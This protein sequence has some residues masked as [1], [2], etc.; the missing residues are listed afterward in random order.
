MTE[1]QLT[2]PVTKKY[3]QDWHAYNLAK[4]NEKRLFYELLYDLS[5]I[6]REPE[7]SF[8]RP[9][10]PIRDLFFC[11]GL[12][13]YSGYSGRKVI[14]DVKHAHGAGLISRAPHFN[15]LTD[16][17]N[18]P[19]TYDLLSKLVTI[20]A[21]PLRKLEDQYSIDSSGFGAYQYE[22]WM[23]VK[24]GSKKGYRNYLKGHVMIGTRTNIICSCEITPGNFSD[25][26]QMPSLLFKTKDNFTVKEVSADKAYTSKMMFRIMGSLGM[27]P[28]IPFKH[29]A[30]LAK[31][32][33]APLWNEM[34]LFFK[35]NQKK[36]A[37][38]Y[39]RRS[40]VET[41]FSMIKVR[42]GEFLK[43]KTYTAQRNELLMKFIC[44]NICCL[45]QEMYENDVKVDFRECSIKF[46]DRKVPVEFVT[47][48]A[49]KV[50]D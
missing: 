12:K 13:L 4:T 41:V 43:C 45:I 5:R 22:R 40:N 44:H 30:K 34:F 23:R 50:E 9:P 27:L 3:T 20:S 28:V 8:G 26:K 21:M 35:N 42:L 48:D 36:F 38:K 2:L 46:I 24:W 29:N 11:L 17:M 39:H 31:E 33:D 25:V 6:I 10:V 1:Q 15:T 49:S 14:S 47:R 37:E 16:F 19:A 18:C 32:T 7:Y